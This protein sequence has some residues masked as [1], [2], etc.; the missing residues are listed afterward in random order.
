MLPLNANSTCIKGERKIWSHT[1]NFA[2]RIT[3]LFEHL[4]TPN[5][6]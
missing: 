6:A 1:M 2:I 5:D 3:L 4:A